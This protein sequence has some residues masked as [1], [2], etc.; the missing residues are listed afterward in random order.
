[1]L[2]RPNIVKKCQLRDSKQMRTITKI[3]IIKIASKLHKSGKIM[4]LVEI[5]IGEVQ[6]LL[7]IIENNF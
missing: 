6:Y 3:K 5:L 4:E 2:L 7:R 1:M